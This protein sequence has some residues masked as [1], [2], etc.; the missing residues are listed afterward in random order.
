MCYKSIFE[1]E[2]LDFTP[3]DLIDR[4]NEIRSTVIEQ[5]NSLFLGQID[6]FIHKIELFGFHFATLDIRQDSSAH[7]AVFDEILA[8]AKA[9]LS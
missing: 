7:D 5:H 1:K 6:S 2:V 8:F 9:K 4:M 3:Q